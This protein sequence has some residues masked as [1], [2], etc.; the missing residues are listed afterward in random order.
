LAYSP[1]LALLVVGLDAATTNFWQGARAM[2]RAVS[3]SA[4]I[5]ACCLVGV[6]AQQPPGGG[7]KIGIAQSLQN[8]YNNL[9]RNLTQAAE[10]MPEADYTSKPSSMSEVRTYG[11]LFSHI[12][13][14]QFA[15]CSA[16]KGVPNPN[17]GK[18]L[19]EELKTKAEITKALADSFALCDDAF[20]A[21][22]DDNALQPVRQGNNEVTRA[23]AL[24]GVLVHGNE[25]YGTA[26]VYLRAKGIVP[27][28]TEGR[29]R[30]R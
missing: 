19:E 2:K 30:R 11:Q 4:S 18:N 5:A 10:K 24:Y 28:S 23:A 29:G 9:K 3:I 8:G 26:A 15:Q 7:Q 21:T 14:A 16:I 1:T 27:P 20:S 13:N 22:T 17:Q 6:S 25:M 12:A